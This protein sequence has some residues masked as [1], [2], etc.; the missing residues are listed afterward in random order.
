MKNFLTFKYFKGDALGGITAGIVALPLALAFG[1]QSGMG[2]AAGLYGAAF[3]AFFAALLGGT[4]T[5]ISGPTAPMTALSVVIVTGLY[6]VYEGKS[7][8]AIPMILMIFLLAGIIQV[9]L[10]LFKAGTYIKYIPY[11]VVSG[12]MTGIGVII[13]ITQIPPM[14]GY[15]VT[16]DQQV[17]EQFKP[18][19]EDL[20]LKRV[21][22][23]K[24][25][26]GV[27]AVDSF[28]KTYN[29]LDSIHPEQVMME[30]QNL[31]RTDAKGVIGSIKYLPRA[32]S[33]INWTEF[34][35]A[36]S[37]I[38]IIFGFKKITTT[39]PSALVALLLVSGV[40]Y[41]LQ[42][43]GHIA[44]KPIQP[45]P[46]GIPKFNHE[47][48]IDPDFAALVP[49]IIFALLLALL[50][51]IDSLL[52]SIVADN[53]TKTQHKPNRELIGQG[54][55][56]SIA[57]LFGGLPGA[58]ATIRTV[59][60]IQ[61]GGKTKLSGMIAGVLLFIII[62]ALGPI[63][64]KIPSAVLAG[65]LITVG[66][67]VMDYKGLRA[68]PKMT[69]SEKFI[70]ITV[71]LLTVF[72]QLVYAVAIGLVIAAFVFLKRMSDISIEK[73][74]IRNLEEAQKESALWDDE[75]EISEEMRDKV[76]FKHLDGPMFFGIVSDFKNL[77]TEFKDIHLL[78]IRLEHVPFFDQSGYYALETLIEQSHDRG[79]VVALCGA[80]EEI[81]KEMKTHKIVPDMI[82]DRHYFM[83][84][85]ECRN[86]L[87]EVLEKENGVEEEMKLIAKPAS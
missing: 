31:A 86:W 85:D 34:L 57:A 18:L 26:D 17:V 54:I 46:E 68:L 20:L 79:V 10:G 59:V 60:N 12:F 66:I 73:I 30:A 80:N 87:R 76:I 16:K 82:S 9:V 4:P 45:I 7:E 13:L 58:G 47:L 24:A 14:L 74:E 29:Y 64:S 43:E 55:G 19:G 44:Y 11:T 36:L 5:Q 50:G 2:A 32:F 28:R 77:V 56:N 65:I 63:A 81:N 42:L 71:L 78:V 8:Q 52:T 62:I 21:I 53:M 70:L 67:G 27:L 83:H 40:A 38:L 75:V 35:L 25:V 72:W 23:K 61:A 33:A 1:E 3:I 37:T 84:F 69:N 48:F 49:Y 6:T 41:W 15:D 22:D 51:S 39:I